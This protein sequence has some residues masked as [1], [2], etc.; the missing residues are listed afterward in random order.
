M[1][2][3]L[4]WLDSQHAEMVGL[5]Q[6][7]V[8][9]NTHSANLAGLK[10]FTQDLSQAFS[11]FNEPI[12]IIAL[13]SY[14]VINHH[15]DPEEHN[16]APA[17]ALGKR[18]QAAH[19]ILLVGHMDTV[20]PL[21]SP[22]QTC[23]AQEDGTIWGPGITDMKGGL[24]VML[25]ALQALERCSWKDQVGW[26]VVIN[27]DEELGSPA[28]G[29]FLKETAAGYDLGMVFEPS[30][31]NGD[32]VSE[33]K[34]SGN[35]TLVIHGKAAH[36]GRNPQDG[37]SAIDAAAAWISE[38]KDFFRNQHDLTIN[39]GQIFGGTAQ[40]VVAERAIVRFNVRCQDQNV[41]TYYQEQMP[42]I[43]QRIAAEHRVRLKI[44]GGFQAPPKP[45]TP[46]LKHVLELLR[47]SAAE[48]GFGL[49]WQASGGV[50]DGN[51]LAAAGLPTIDTLGVKGGHIHSS[52][53]YVEPDSFSQ[54]AKLA[55]MF[56]QQ[57]MKERESRHG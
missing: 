29:Q 49:H 37:R 12:E 45:M 52:Q 24:V 2:E 10:S 15:G 33:R 32:L 30:L 36:A 25:Y 50:C 46:Q 57:W 41:Q 47:G 34:G 4:S 9:I 21:D 44:Y 1:H 3:I 43:N 22:F 35:F 40:N 16:V 51:R 26:K 27:T 14:E 5:A 20:Y 11:I 8:D 6:R 38:A 17:I 55:I 42:L 28:S 7:W 48:L 13:P 19:Q 39:I 31:P 54:R 23:V 53:E 18:P 56:I